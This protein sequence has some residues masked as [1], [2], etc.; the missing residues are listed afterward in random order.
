MSVS[1]SDARLIFD[2]AIFQPK[3]S[4]YALVIPVLNEGE[5]ITAQL[6]RI[7]NIAHGMDVIIADGGSS[8]GATRPDVLTQAGVRACLT[9]RDSG[10]LSA[11]LRMAFGWCLEQGYDGIVTIDGN[12][13]D[14]VEA[15]P[16]FTEKLDAGY[17]FIQGSRYLPDGEAV[18]TP[19]DRHLAVKLIHAPVVSM[20]AGVRFTDTTNGFRGISAA[21]LRDSRVA[22]FRACFTGYSLLFYL[23][24]RAGQLGLK[25]I[26]IPVR[27]AYP[28]TGKIPTK[29]GA[30]RGKIQILRE[31]FSAAFGRY[32]PK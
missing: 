20:A 9:L 13:K 15:L 31:L 3:S 19:L 26:E 25:T 28:E 17:D 23:S 21:M 6:G 30:V 7:A 16:R 5:R 2:T 32:T 22:P 18:N 10:K 24:V 29:I 1:P 4:R 12:G 14:G 8:D 11:Q 27:R